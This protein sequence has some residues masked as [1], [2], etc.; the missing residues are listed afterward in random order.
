MRCI[1]VDKK[2][3]EGKIRQMSIT[4]RI[5][6]LSDAATPQILTHIEQAISEQ[7]YE[8]FTVNQCSTKHD[9]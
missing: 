7:L 5:T 3:A 4:E 8:D 1:K 2:E 6:R 9:I